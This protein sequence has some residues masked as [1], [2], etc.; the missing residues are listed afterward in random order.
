MNMIY[1]FARI[2]YKTYQNLANYKTRL[3]AMRPTKI[4]TTQLDLFKN[5]LSVQLNPKHELYKLSNLIPWD[6][7]EK[8]FN[9]HDEDQVAG[10]PSKPVRLMLGI[11]LLQNMYNLSDENAVRMWVENPYWQYFC[12]YNIL[13][14][15]Y[16]IDP[17]SLT[18]WRNR[19]GP[20]SLEKL[21]SMSVDVAVETGTIEKKDLENII[22]DTT[23]MPKNIE[24]PTDAKLLEKARVRMVKLAKEHNLNLRQNYNF[25]I[26]KL[27]RRLGGY[28]H[29]K[30]MKR[31]QKEQKT[32]RTL[33]GRI[34][35][36]C[37]RQ[38]ANDAKLEVIFKDILSQSNHLL[39]RKSKDKNK[40]YSLHEPSVDCISKGKA[41]KKYE[42][43][44]KVSLTICH[45]AKGI[46]TSALAIAGNPYDGH[47]LSEAINASER[48]TNQKVK[49]AFV[50][51]GYKGHGVENTIVYIS[52]QRKDITSRIKKEMKRRQAIEPYIGHIKSECKLGLS[53]LKGIVGDKINAI[54][55][56]AAYN[57]KLIMNHLRVLFLQILFCIFK[58]TKFTY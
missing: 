3:A 43:G 16:P 13:Q 2:R 20:E 11:M 39:T 49:K 23:V 6:R 38:V 1:S 8:E 45:R 44:T 18:R 46:I 58:N 25:V 15:E 56:A 24:Y 26:K 5:Q 14:W 17:S 12:G 31:A 51:K 54:L 41:H 7:L 21:L 35:R 53:R 30:Q 55:S 10:R 57:L 50:D 33:V 9:L 48:I 4:E 19:L 28:L 27:L 47:T 22:A 29:A 32:L 37:E 40:I 34:T 52:G 36:D 42:F